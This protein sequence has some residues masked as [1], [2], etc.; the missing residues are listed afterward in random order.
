[1]IDCST[2]S[3]VEAEII[4]ESLREKYYEKDMVSSALT[5]SHSCLVLEPID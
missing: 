5:S 3:S 4:P 1:M 2:N